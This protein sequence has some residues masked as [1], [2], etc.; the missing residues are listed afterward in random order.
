MMILALRKALFAAAAS[1]TLL[2]ATRH[3][4]GPVGFGGGGG[5]NCSLPPRMPFGGKVPMSNM[6]NFSSTDDYQ[7]DEVQEEKQEN[8][9]N[10][11][12]PTLFDD[13]GFFS[14]LLPRQEGVDMDKQQRNRYDTGFVA[15]DSRY[16]AL[17]KLHQQRNL[18]KQMMEEYE[19]KKRQQKKD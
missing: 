9:D 13:G 19:K 2:T 3:F 17:V 14:D 15:P 1:K 7:F 8:N 11:D 5:G 4:W 16:A 6:S 18:K 10:D 12:G